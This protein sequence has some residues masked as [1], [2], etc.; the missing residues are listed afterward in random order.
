MSFRFMPPPSLA[1]VSRGFHRPFPRAFHEAVLAKGWQPV[2][3]DG[4]PFY[5][6]PSGTGPA[7]ALIGAVLT[8]AS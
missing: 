3:V 6:P 4:A 1:R 5:L 7:R 8:R 2:D